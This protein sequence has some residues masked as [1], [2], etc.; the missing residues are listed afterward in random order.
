MTSQRPYRDNLD[1]PS[2][3]K[4]VWLNQGKQFDP[5]IAKTLSQCQLQINLVMSNSN[6]M[7]E[8]LI[9]DLR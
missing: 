4:E 9:Q 8:L 6:K 3:V 7:K 5:K 1:F 2:A